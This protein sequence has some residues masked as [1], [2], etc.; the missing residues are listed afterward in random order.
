MASRLSKTGF[1]YHLTAFLAINSILLWINFDTTPDKLWALWP[2]A[3]WGIGLVFHGL[4][5][6]LSSGIK[7][8]GLAYHFAAYAMVNA[9]LA[10][11]NLT[12]SP[13]YVWFKFPL[14]AW[15]FMILFHGW[16]VFSKK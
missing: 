5:V 15:T 4:S 13:G 8:K 14:I 2:I 9:L 7:Q 11:I 6:A 3:G 10:Y 12:Y 16:T 1:A